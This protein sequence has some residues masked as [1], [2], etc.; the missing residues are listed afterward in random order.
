MGG[1]ENFGIRAPSLVR[2]M[3]RRG[4]FAVRAALAALLV[5]LLAPTAAAAARP[6]APQSPP[7][8][9]FVVVDVNTGTVLA[10]DHQHDALP[11]ASTSKVMTA[12]TAVERLAPDALVNVSPLA[13]SQPASRINM[14]PGQQWPLNN[15][16]ASL[17]LASA[18]DAAY[19]IAETA[20][21]SLDGFVAAEQQTAARLG[22]EDSTFSDPAG[23]DDETSYKGGPRMSAY[24]IAISTRN[25]LAVPDLAQWGATRKYEFVDPT[26]LPRSLTNHNRMLPGGTRAY[27]FAT[28]FKTGFTSRAGHTLIA[29]ATRDGRS[30]IAVILDTYDTYGWAVQLLDQG[31]ATPNAQGTGE[32][33][34][35][36]AVSPYAD[37]VADQQAFLTAARAPRPRR[38]R[39]RPPVPALRPPRRRRRRPPSRRRPRS[40]RRRASSTAM[41]S[42]RS[43]RP[44]T[45]VV[46]VAAPAAS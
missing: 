34:P 22:M 28:G 27:E 46:E 29:T 25:A 10:S 12:L 24:D 39:L 41:P 3:A 30:L 37:R 2:S 36:V 42:P 40:R 26:G 4:R 35:V 8:K 20:G 32:V 14:Q 31:F 1:T 19:A 5:G 15:A 16:L 7:P 43:R 45:A 21:G 11:P 33:L 44:T 13:A 18:N 23:L 9:A 6:A 17:L 38:P